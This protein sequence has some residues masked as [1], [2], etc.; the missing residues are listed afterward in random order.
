MARQK[1]HKT[2]MVVKEVGG[3]N[4]LGHCSG[5][6]KTLYGSF[7]QSLPIGEI[8]DAIFTPHKKE[9]T[10]PQLGYWYAV[11][12]PFS[13][14]ELLKLGHNEIP[15]F[16]IDGEPVQTNEGTVDLMYKVKLAKYQVLELKRDKPSKGILEKGN[17]TVDEMSEL[18]EFAIKWL[19]EKLQVAP[20]PPDPELRS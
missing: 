5:L 13:V 14:L 6:H 9:K 16:T 19:R 2:Q 4:A 20:Q 17:M 11:I 3:E 18:I 10:P 12:L 7:L 1:P 15:D 8:V